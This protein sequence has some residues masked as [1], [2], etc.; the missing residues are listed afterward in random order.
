MR[1]NGSV[2]QIEAG[3]KVVT[4]LTS[5]CRRQ[6]LPH[7]SFCY[8]SPHYTENVAVYQG[9]FYEVCVVNRGVGFYNPAP[10]SFALA[11]MPGGGREVPPPRAETAE[12]SPQ[13]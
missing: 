9:R 10:L 3:R 11:E 2:R 13:N 7:N 4:H 5:L 12:E 1:Y 6:D 8:A